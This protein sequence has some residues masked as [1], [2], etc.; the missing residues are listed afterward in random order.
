MVCLNW[1]LSEE[2][3]DLETELT[4]GF[5]DHLLLGTPASPLRRILL[6]SGLGDAI[7]GGGIEDE[8]LQPQFSVG[9]KGVSE[10]DI[11]KVEEL[12]METLKSLAEEGFAPE[13]VEASMNTIEFSLRENNTDKASHDEAVEKEILDKVKSSMTKE[14]LAELARA[15]QELRLKQETPDP[16]EALRSIPSLSL[17]DIPRKPI[18]VPTEVSL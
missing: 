12:I 14:D 7:V 16:P 8:L 15:T 17:Q 11:H 13:A 18:H 9:L 6:E 2:P 4:L 10:D 3:L 5:L 1:L